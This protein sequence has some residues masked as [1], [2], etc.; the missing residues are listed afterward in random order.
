VKLTSGAITVRPNQGATKKNSSK[1]TTTTTTP[2]TTTA[3]LSPLT[4]TTEERFISNTTRDQN[5]SFHTLSTSSTEMPERT[6][7]DTVGKSN[8]TFKKSEG[9]ESSGANKNRVINAVSL[10]VAILLMMVLV[11]KRKKIAAYF[12]WARCHPTCGCRSSDAELG[13]VTEGSVLD[14]VSGQ[15]VSVVAKGGE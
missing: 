7:A 11:V 5:T 13:R 15:P 1:T 9:L 12:Q 14:D 4:M 6:T 8:P 2:K 3:S 10:S